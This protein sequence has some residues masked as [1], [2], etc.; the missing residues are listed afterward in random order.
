M[1]AYSVD[2][3]NAAWDR[4]G[5]KEPPPPPPPAPP[6]TSAIA[7]LKQAQS[8]IGQH[9]SPFGS[10]RT[11]YGAWYGFNA[12][13]WCAIFTTWSD[14]T[15]EHPSGSLKKGSRYSYVP[16]IVFYA[17]RGLHGLYVTSNPAPG[18][19]VC[20]DWGGDGVFDHVGIVESGLDS[21]GNFKTVEGNTS[22]SN[23]SNG[24][25]VARCNRNKYHYRCVFVRVKD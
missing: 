22:G 17:Q 3:I 21:K 19:L 25:S 14:Q 5:G 11:K 24:G 8:Q 20:F 12:V 7:R 6:I 4:F 2:L 1:D 16:D 23:W 18:D 13:P 10:N 9:E 15:S